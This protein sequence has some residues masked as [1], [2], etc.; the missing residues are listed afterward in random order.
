V[1]GNRPQQPKRMKERTKHINTGKKR[2]QAVWCDFFMIQRR[3]LL[4]GCLVHL[5]EEK[6]PKR[7]KQVI[8]GSKITAKFTSEKGGR[9]QG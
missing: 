3:K 6:H 5:G 2:I 4:E 9:G 8:S 7:R 1:R